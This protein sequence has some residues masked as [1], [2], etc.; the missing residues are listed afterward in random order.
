MGIVKEP[1]GVDFVVDSRSLT[2]SEK[3]EI[4]DVIA[5]YKKT[6]N[7]KITSATKNKKQSKKESDSII[8]KK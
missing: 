3:S 6:G 1:K 2:N 8:S 4:S 5:Q 7:I